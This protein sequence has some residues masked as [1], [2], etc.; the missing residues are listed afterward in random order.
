LVEQAK[1]LFTEAEEN[2]LGEKALTERWQRW[3]VCSLCEQHY[4]GVVRSALGWACWKT[5]LGRPEADR[6]RSSALG[7]LGAGLSDAKH[8]EAALSVKR[9]NLAMMRRVGAPEYSILVAQ[10]NLAVTYGRLGRLEEALRLKRDVYSGHVKLNGEGHLDSLG[11]A[12]NYASSL[13]RLERFEEVKALLR[14]TLPVARRVLD[15]SDELALG[16]RC[17]YAR[18]LYGDPNATLDDLRE[19]VTILGEAGR[20]ARRVFGGAHPLTTWI[21][22]ELQNSRAALAAWKATSSLLEPLREAVEAMTP[23]DA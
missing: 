1:I 17:N 10:N 3:D 5:Y 8:H 20:T 21:E 9:A 4:H 12:N 19:A 11:A 23:G 15:E 7:L 22:R 16:M 2:N 13:I 18:A 6:V 14:K